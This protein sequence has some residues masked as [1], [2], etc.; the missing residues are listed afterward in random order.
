M[1]IALLTEFATNKREP[2]AALLERIHSAFIASGLGE[3]DLQFACSDAPVPGFVSSVGRVLKR[4]P[5]LQRFVPS[6]DPTMPGAPPFRR[7]AAGPLSPA[8][9]EAIEFSL[10]HAIAAGVPRSFPFHDFTVRFAAPAFGEEHPLGALAGGNMPGV[11]VTNSW[12]V[13]GRQRFVAAMTIVDA[14]PANPA[15]PSPPEPVAKILAACGK[16]RSTRQIPFAAMPDS[17][18]AAKAAGPSPE[19][20]R[21]VVAVVQNYR[22]QFGDMIEQANLPHDLPSSREALTT[23]GLGQRSGP[24]KP[25]LARAFKPL[26]YDCR[27]DSGT[28]TLRRRTPGNLTVEIMLNVGTWSRSVTAMFLVHGLGFRSSLH[29]PVAK[30][31][32]DG[33]QYPIGG[34]ERW[35]QIV[36]NLAALVAELDRT[37]V[38]AIEAVSGPTP[39]WYRPES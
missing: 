5:N 1:R 38:P 25:G 24:M 26:G 32:V 15:L 2:V 29:L 20:A 12:W 27:G 34:Q 3:P 39:S 31:A 30:R 22:A 33:G 18:T 9:G 23:T 16:M 28:F 37:F 13:N 8:P 6:E 14:D 7:I 36:E 10:L 11:V 4:H 35:Q 21:A 17:A 19:V